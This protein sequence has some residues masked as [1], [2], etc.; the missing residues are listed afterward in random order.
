[1][2]KT[3]APHPPL[4]RY[5]DDPS[6]R[7]AFV[8]DIF[9][10]TARW[11]DMAA[12]MLSFGSGDF[13]RREAMKRAGARPG[14]RHLDLAT[15]TGVVAR[16]AAAVTGDPRS[17]VG[18][19][20]S[21]GM[22][23]AGRTAGAK[24]QAPAELLPFADT[25]FDLIT[26]GFALRHFADLGVVFRECR[27]V[28]RPGGK[29][30]ILEVTAPENA[31]ARAILGL[32]MGTIAPA[33]IRLRTGSSRAAEMVRYYWETTR[34]CVRPEVILDALRDAGFSEVSRDVQLAI[35][36]EYSAVS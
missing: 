6:K 10:D 15:G 3:I 27:R 22:L 9:D 36:S 11:Y 33:I 12:N 17:I 24:V 1:M 31:V 23:H 5:Y 28:L 32:H 26:I 34:N 13:Y 8:R 16:A 4:T 18:M 14:L 20:P 30:V 35:F 21:I 29:L 7:E 25:S 19:D 2:T